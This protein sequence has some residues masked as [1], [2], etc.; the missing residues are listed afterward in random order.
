MPRYSRKKSHTGYY[1]VILRGVNRQDIFFDDEDRHQFIETIKRFQN[2]LNVQITAYCLMSNHVHILLQANEE[3]SVFVKKISS[4][5]VFWF[6]RKYGRVGHLFQDRFKSEAID[7]DSYLMTA[8]R[9]ILHNPQKAGICPVERYKWSSFSEIEKG[10]FCDITIPCK[11][12]GD[13]KTLFDSICSDNED[14]CMDLENNRFLSEQDVIA[15]IRDFSGLENPL[16][17]SCMEKDKR[18]LLF[19]ELKRNGASIRQL[20]RITGVNRNLIQRAK[21]RAN[22]AKGTSLNLTHFAAKSAFKRFIS[23]SA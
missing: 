9:Y 11:I 3:L 17:V 2:E 12:A 4:S 8:M 16:E 5:Y 21:G 23:C 1:H 20:S 13:K 19:S 15:M 14:Q 22:R 7:S 18:D 10:G 6:N